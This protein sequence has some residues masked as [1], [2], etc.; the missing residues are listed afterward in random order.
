VIREQVELYEALAP[1]GSP[2]MPGRE[3]EDV[4]VDG[5]A[6]QSASGD[7][8]NLTPSAPEADRR[9]ADEGADVLPFRKA[10]GS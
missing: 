9:A 8:R 7:D 4:P 5:E 10:A 2:G 6:P 3:A 1:Q